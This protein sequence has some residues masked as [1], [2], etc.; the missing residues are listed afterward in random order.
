MIFL[1]SVID[2]CLYYYEDDSFS[3][4]SFD[5]WSENGPVR[6]LRHLSE[7]RGDWRSSQQL[8]NEKGAHQVK[9]PWPFTEMWGFF[10]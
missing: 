1:G 5:S 4:F 10:I 6:L 7:K 9:T 2:L 8:K 3:T